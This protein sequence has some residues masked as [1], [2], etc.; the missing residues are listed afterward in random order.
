MEGIG[1]LAEKLEAIGLNV[2]QAKTEE[3][4]KSPGP[5]PSRRCA[6]YF[7]PAP[8][9]RLSCHELSVTT[10]LNLKSKVHDFQV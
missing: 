4:A 5:C 6:L 10:C 9:R 7:V 2:N 8:S 3:G 1:V